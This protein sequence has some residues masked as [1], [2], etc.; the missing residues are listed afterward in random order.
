MQDIKKLWKKNNLNNEIVNTNLTKLVPEAKIIVC[1]YVGTTFFELMANDTP[2]I[3]F[4]KLSENSFSEEFN[5][6]MKKLKNFNFLFYS[7]Y[8][9]AKFLNE[10]HHNFFNLWNDVEFSKFREEF[11]DKW[12]KKEKNWQE[13]FIKNIH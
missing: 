9:A 1:S 13:I 6:Y 8:S 2:F 7:S 4:T 12:C 3:T 11:R 10:N 5:L